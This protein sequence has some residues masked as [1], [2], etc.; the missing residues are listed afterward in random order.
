MRGHAAASLLVNGVC[1][2]IPNIPRVRARAFHLLNGQVKKGTDKNAQVELRYIKLVGFSD[3]NNL[4]AQG[5]GARDVRV[6]LRVEAGDV[7]VFSGTEDN[8]A[9][10]VAAPRTRFCRL[11]ARSRPH[12]PA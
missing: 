9:P 1:L 10:C 5:A 3:V 11:L 7:Q 8:L 4:P 6:A 12:S 2:L